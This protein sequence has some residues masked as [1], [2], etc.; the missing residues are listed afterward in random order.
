MIYCNEV[1]RLKRILVI[2]LC[3]V[4]IFQV[5]CSQ[6][7]PDKSENGSQETASSLIFPSGIVYDETKDPLIQFAEHPSEINYVQVEDAGSYP[8]FEDVIQTISYIAEAV[9]LGCVYRDEKQKQLQNQYECWFRLER[10]IY[11]ESLEKLFCFK[12][13]DHSYD[14][15]KSNA[16][17]Y[18]TVEAYSKFEKGKKYLLFLSQIHSVFFDDP[19]YSL[20]GMV[21]FDL[22]NAPNE[23][24]LMGKRFCDI[25]PS[26]R[27]EIPSKWNWFYDYLQAKLNQRE[28]LKKDVFDYIH[29][30]DLSQI[31]KESAE[32]YRL[33]ILKQADQSKSLN[34]ETFSVEILSSLKKESP[35]ERKY[36]RVP[37]GT[38]TEG[39]EYLMLFLY[40]E[41]KT[42]GD[43]N[44]DLSSKHSIRPISEEETIRKIIAQ[45]ESEKAE[46]SQ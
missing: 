25:H 39:K 31:V 38:V 1:I 18:S 5:G 12:W 10:Q 46:T 17:A 3:A 22:R 11:G 9:Y 30:E 42:T 36:V 14:G 4:L 41:N 23:G 33:R 6:Q 43:I 37:A 45:Q 44:T 27:E 15:G 28:P 32:I 34:T 29:S 24:Y 7:I 16:W 19:Y 21:F 40:Q 8:T 20:E 26:V 13:S 2:V 35:Y